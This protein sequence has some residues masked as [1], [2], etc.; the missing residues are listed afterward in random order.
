[1]NNLKLVFPAHLQCGYSVL[2]ENQEMTDYDVLVVG[3]GI[4]GLSTAYHIKHADPALKVLVVDKNVAEGLGS[5]VNSAAAFSLPAQTS[6]WQ[7]LPWSSTSTCRR[8][9]GLI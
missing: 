9:W 6:P 7:I 8:I 4:L 3:A 5:T 2:G 1:M